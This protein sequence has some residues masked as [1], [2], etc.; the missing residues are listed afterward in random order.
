MTIHGVPNLS[1][2]MPNRSAENVVSIGISTDP[3]SA[4][5]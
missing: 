2:H 5:A 3:P 4:S 1:V